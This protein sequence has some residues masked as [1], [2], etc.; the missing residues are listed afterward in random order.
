MRRSS[1]VGLA[2]VAAL[3]LVLYLTFP[4]RTSTGGEDAQKGEGTA[5][6]WINEIYLSVPPASVQAKGG[7]GSDLTERVLD[8]IDWGVSEVQN[9]SL[10]QLA[11]QSDA[12]ALAAAR[13]SELLTTRS[14][15]A[16]YAGRLLEFLGRAH[17]AEH[18]DVVLSALDSPA[19]TLR[20]AAVK[21]LG[22]M[23]TP[24]AHDKVLEL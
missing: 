6:H 18:M 17:A 24:A 7:A 2:V 5:R 19:E 15:D 3:G 22:S 20:R 16:F 4:R 13:V 10:R 14:L 8:R 21:A 23:G 1:L 11:R 9:Y 12:P